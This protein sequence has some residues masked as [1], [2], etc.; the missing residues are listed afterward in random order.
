MV[1]TRDI[2]DDK[3]LEARGIAGPHQHLLDVP[4]YTTIS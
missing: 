4:R 1:P 3:S 2:D